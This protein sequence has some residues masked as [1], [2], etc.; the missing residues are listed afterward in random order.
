[1]HPP[2]DDAGLCVYL[3]GRFEVRAG[4]RL[5]IDQSWPRRKAKAL[6]KLLALNRGQWLHREQILETLWPGLE[7]AAADH[8]LRQ[9]LHY[10][11]EAFA[12][13]SLTL[14]VVTAARSTFALSEEARVD[15]EAFRDCAQ[16]ARR[17]RTDPDLY[18][19]ALA[20]Y[21]GDL[22]PEDIYDDWAQ[23]CREEL[24]ALR[25]Q[26]LLELAQLHRL[27]G[28]SEAAAERLE[29]LVRLDPLDE[30]GHRALM[31]VYAESGNRQRAVRQYDKCRG[32]LKDDLGVEPSEETEVFYRKILEG[33]DQTPARPAPPS[34]PFIG[35][36][37]EMGLLRAGLEEV[38]AGRGQCFI[39]AG[40]AGIGKTRIAE[41]L[42]LHAGLS[43]VQVLWGR[44]YEGEGA[45]AY[46]PWVQVVRSYV[47][48]HSAEELKTV[49][50]F[51]TTDVAALVPEVR[52][53]LP[54]LEVAAPAESEH[55]R[56]RLFDSLTTLLKNA[57]ERQALAL[58]LDDLHR[59]DEPSLLVL[60]FL[61]S[62]LPR[63]HLLLL[64]TY[65]DTEVAP[66]SRLH[67][68]VAT[69]E[70]HH[71]GHTI[72]L[73]GL[74]ER[75]V[76][77]LMEVSFGGEAPERLVATMYDQTGGSPFLVREL[78][79]VL[80]AAGSPEW[81][82]D[83]PGW[84]IVL[85][86]GARAVI[87]HS[88]D[89]LSAGCRKVLTVASVIGKDFGL[90]VLGRVDELRDSPLL[91]AVSEAAAAGVIAQVPEGIGRFTFHHA[92]LREAL[93][94]QLPIAR[95][96]VLHRL[97]GEALEQLYGPDAEGRPAEL[98]YHFLEA[99]P[100]GEVK[101]AGHY[102]RL[103]GDRAMALHAY[104][105]AAR[106]YQKALDVTRLHDAMDEQT[107]SD[108]LLSLG[109][110]TWDAG[111]PAGGRLAFLAAAAV[112]RNL[113]DCEQLARAAL[114]CGRS[115]TSVGTLDQPL[116]DLLE[117]ALAGL[118]EEDA[119]LRAMV[120]ASL[121]RALYWSNA[122][123]QR[124]SLSRQAVE[125]ARRIGDPRA[126]AHILDAAWI[127]L[128]VPE[129]PEERLNLATEML[130]LAEE[131]ADKARAHQAHRWRMIALLELGEIAAARQEFQAQ[132]R[133]A[134][135]LRQPAQLENASVVAAMLALFEG[136]F[137]EAERLARDALANAERAHDWAAA[138]QFGAQMIA[139]LR[140]R[141]RLQEIEPM[142]RAF[143]EQNPAVAAWRSVLA[144]IYSQQGRE[145][146]A[147][148]EFE[149]LA[150]DEF[151]C[152]PRDYT[153]LMATSLLADVCSF[154]KDRG[155]AAVLYQQLLP[156]ARRNIVMGYAIVCAGSVARSL[157][158]LAA[159]LGRWREAERHFED[160]LEMNER[161]GALP[162]LAWTQHDYGRMLV[163]RSHRGDA[164][165]AAHL[166]D[167]ALTNARELG[168]AALEVTALALI[169]DLQ[170]AG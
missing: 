152:L 110:A 34:G 105:E 38:I 111:D 120:L 158:L 64:S 98:A 54:D 37:R 103:A 63:S 127:A 1:M 3:L 163:E 16:T 135:E 67:T 13:Q 15:V 138:E 113:G 125:M 82:L 27:R 137:D 147:R 29:E 57:A 91:E 109:R 18:E 66:G 56:F 71:P 35:R 133:I 124:L 160:A 49:A 5:I 154:L 126:L 20:I 150:A 101:K 167:R 21:R 51:G 46:W 78:T 44:C 132:M 149:R 155:R 84:S 83:E 94:S 114:G 33:C 60:E 59:A 95:R 23:P 168:M 42:A 99:G 79:Q 166:L 30:E 142:V 153:W 50:G 157:G 134:A 121:A 39:I 72:H 108:L 97:V 43:G 41:E 123:E 7:P 47:R 165:R 25:R 164:G 139:L 19:R 69:L 88:L 31:R 2:Q 73:E 9:N 141:D 76:G 62:E 10:L 96:S 161:M 80:V 61:A 77:R 22:A 90:D 100:A 122:S 75:D 119:P 81:S 151:A 58:I 36:E 148:T 118:S 40:E 85:P 68:T 17:A 107:R 136:R 93:Y 106:L 112:A 52:L 156:F 53:A 144:W 104:E 8:N 14:P 11:R 128:W 26:L 87:F 102:A 32:A 12:A 55:G 140:E 129:N 115:L 116:V 92:L 169:D 89:R 24:K 117:E 48:Q 159:T 143:V 145:P 130:R 146:E 4:D 45:P 28:R 162:W 170:A 65:R 70:R 6:L 86:H 131:T 74:C